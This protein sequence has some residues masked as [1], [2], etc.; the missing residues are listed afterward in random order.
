MT[1]AEVEEYGNRVEQMARK[2]P[3]YEGWGF[4]RWNPVTD[5]CKKP[6]IEIMYGCEKNTR[7]YF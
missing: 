3:A 4:F 7:K 2:E 5:V 1:P 6:I